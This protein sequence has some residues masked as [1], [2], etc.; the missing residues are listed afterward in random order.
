MSYDEI[1]L[2]STGVITW[3]TLFCQFSTS[4]NHMSRVFL[5]QH[6]MITTT[7]WALDH[8]KKSCSNVKKL[9]S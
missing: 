8:T 4:M 3:L 1:K 5:G 9:W 2:A 6:V 7:F